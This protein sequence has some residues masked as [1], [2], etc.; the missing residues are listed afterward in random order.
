MKT[1]QNQEDHEELIT[2][3]FMMANAAMKHALRMAE[4][5]NAI[6]K[7]E[8][9]YK[10]QGRDA[11]IFPEVDIILEPEKKFIKVKFKKQEKA[12]VADIGHG[13]G[14]ISYFIEGDDDFL[15]SCNVIPYRPS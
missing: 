11:E 9:F 12:Q 15:R 13:Q 10:K 4:V 7:L 1:E 5:K 14:K 6:G 2:N 8:E 3:L